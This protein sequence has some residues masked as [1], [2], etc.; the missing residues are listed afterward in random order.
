MCVHAGTWECLC[1]CVQACSRV[2]VSLWEVCTDVQLWAFV[3]LNVC[4]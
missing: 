1:A 3:R 4:I 2:R